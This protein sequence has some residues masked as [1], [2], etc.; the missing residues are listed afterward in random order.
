MGLHMGICHGEV[1][2]IVEIKVGDRTVW[3]YNP[4]APPLPPLESFEALA[5]W[6]ENGDG[7]AFLMPDPAIPAYEYTINDR[8]EWPDPITS[9]KRIPIKAGQI[10][11]GDDGEGGVDGFLDV[12]M[13][14]PTQ[15]VNP[16][17]QQMLG[18]LVPAYRGRVT[19]FFDGL[20]CSMSKYPKSWAIKPKR[21]FAGW[22]GGVWYSAKA[23]IALADGKI[24]ARNPAHI[25]YEC[26][27]NRMWGRGFPRAKLDDASFRACADVLFSESFGMCIRWARQDTINSFIQLVQNHIGADLYPS[28]T[29][30]L[31][32]L[33]LV[34]DDYDVDALPYFDADSGLLSIELDENADNAK[35]VN[36]ITVSYTR[37][38]DDSEGSMR[39]FNSAAI[40]ANGLIPDTASY[41]GLP[42]P[43]L[44]LRVGQRDLRAKFGLKKFK[45]V[46]DR[47]GYKIEPGGVFS[48]G[49]P[50][51]GIEKLVLRA[52]KID[53][54]KIDSGSITITAMMDVFGLPANSYVGVQESLYTPPNFTPQPV[55]FRSIGEATY[56]D[57]VAVVDSATFNTLTPGT[58][59][60]TAMAASPNGL[61]Y[62]YQ[63]DTNTGGNWVSA[64]CDFTPTAIITSA[65]PLG[66]EFV[67]VDLDEL[68][69]MDAVSVGSVCKINSE[70]FRVI[71]IKL[72]DK[73]VRLARGCVDTVPVA[74]AAG[75]RIWFYQDGL[76]VDTTEYAAG[77]SVNARLLTKTGAGRLPGESAAT[78]VYV[79]GRRRERPYPPGNL[80]I[81]GSVYPAKINGAL[82]VSWSHRDRTLQADQLIDTTVGSVG[83]EPGV[84]Y[85]VVLK[86]EG[87]VTFLSTTASG[88]SLSVAP[89]TEYA[90]GV[91]D[92]PSGRV[93][94]KL[95][96]A[97][98]DNAFS[99]ALDA[100]PTISKASDGVNSG[101]VGQGAN[102]RFATPSG[103]TYTAT[104]SSVGGG[105]SD[106][107]FS[108]KAGVYYSVLPPGQDP[109]TWRD[110]YV[111][112]AVSRFRSPNYY[113]RN[114]GSL[115][116]DR[117][118]NPQ[119]KFQAWT[120]SADFMYWAQTEDS[121]R[122]ISKV[123]VLLDRIG[124]AD[125][126][127][128]SITMH[129]VLVDEFYFADGNQFD[130][131]VGD[132]RAGVG[133]FG[134]DG[135]QYAGAA[136]S[137]IYVAYVGG[138]STI[139]TAGKLVDITNLLTA[140]IDVATAFTTK[141]KV[142]S[143]DG[144]GSVTELA[145]K[146][147][148]YWIDQLTAT[149][150]LELQQS[151]KQVRSIDMATGATVAELVTL[152]GTFLSI[153]ADFPNEVFYALTE[154]AGVMTLRKYDAA[155]TQIAISNF[156]GLNNTCRLSVS[157][158]YIYVHDITAKKLYQSSKDLNGFSL[159]N[160]QALFNMYVISATALTVETFDAFPGDTLVHMT[161][162][163]PYGTGGYSRTASM[164]DESGLS[165][166]DIDVATPRVNDVITVELG[167][168]RDGLNSHQ[169]HIVTVPRLGYGLR[170]GESYED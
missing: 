127:D 34:R 170:Y 43:E 18:G 6:E 8:I 112:W 47:R 121:T 141:T 91:F 62:G 30:G 25:I 143:F 135:I 99:R 96:L 61:S 69:G 139:N 134:A 144:S 117:R 77:V 130:N 137:L 123:Q 149:L 131:P 64:D 1:D 76:G 73:F 3:K 41:P 36:E 40:R 72:A 110:P 75:S 93:L 50:E 114:T 168:T 106:T 120:R 7:I 31:W 107:A 48:I 32:T 161:V 70:L 156:P 145:T 160:P 28:R 124:I 56:R 37:P 79:M 155:G 148:V 100:Y 12:M 27:T 159:I 164:L 118:A 17:L 38:E 136:G 63:L 126:S 113:G 108:I 128:G 169:K 157:Q 55:E 92:A 4:S 15:P 154:S 89:E 88:E 122:R 71:S 153:V 51:R 152:P 162:A 101:Y 21:N 53:D 58:N 9:S 84:E 78:D 119:H 60:L 39:V 90:T 59:F 95:G 83:P 29:T 66:A 35:A 2:E 26:L 65:I 13:G 133:V 102:W 150:G 98:I 16:R 23:Q 111:G 165:S 86:G 54:G 22:D 87:G 52:G 81:N 138:G 151:S 33:R 116:I 11:G 129:R 19:A 67:N 85:S 146:A 68:M 14:E 147:G 24:R 42:T 167:S 80:R 45:V 109:S 97:I 5:E 103:T 125:M 94:R 57:L 46:L 163:S 44:A 74:H 158:N 140:H 10:F 166:E 20:I 132:Y 115:I 142:L 104:V 82:S 105:V 49:A